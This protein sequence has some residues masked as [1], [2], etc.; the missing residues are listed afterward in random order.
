MSLELKSK[1]DIEK[2]RRANMLVYEVH[3]V[4][5][6]MV[7]PGVTTKELDEKAYAMRNR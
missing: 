3:Q 6:E 7:K 1:A 5:R 4:L 2:M